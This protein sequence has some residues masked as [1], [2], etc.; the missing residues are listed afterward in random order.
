MAYLKVEGLQ[1]LLKSFDLTK[2]KANKFIT[3][4]VNEWAD[5]VVLLAKQAAPVNDGKLRQS[6]QADYA[7]SAKIQAGVAVAVNYAAYLEFGTR[8]Y[9]SAYVGSLPNDWK[10]YAASF[11]GKGGGT[12]DEF[13]LAIMD[14]VKSKGISGTYSVKTQKRTKASGKGGN[15]ED[16]EVAYPIALA[17]I[18]KGIKPQ[19]YLYPATITANKHLIDK[20]KKAN[21]KL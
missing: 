16:A 7:T 14:W 6:I 18:R 21:E 10:T 9:A 12:F 13:L 1:E 15:F 11:K 8:G 19:P 20:L 2:D 3:D 17:I 5:E 4:S